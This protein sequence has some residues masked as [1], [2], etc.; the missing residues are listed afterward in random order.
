MKGRDEEDEHTNSGC[1]S[2]VF[3][4]VYGLTSFLGGEEGGG[5]GG[6]GGRGRESDN[7][8]KKIKLEYI[9]GT[10]EVCESIHSIRNTHMY[11]YHYK[12]QAYKLQVQPH[13][14][15][16]MKLVSKSVMR[17]PNSLLTH[18]QMELVKD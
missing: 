11:S 16:T 6:G 10:K 9:R 15:T 8:T 13:T 14:S 18:T 5:G 12:L 2:G 4:R 17:D 3:C 1:R 7:R